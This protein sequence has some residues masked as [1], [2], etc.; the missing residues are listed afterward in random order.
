[1]PTGAPRPAYSQP[2]NRE[3]DP[4]TD[5]TSR[6]R[7]QAFAD[8]YDDTDFIA[9][10]GEH[11]LLHSDLVDALASPAT[12]PDAAR[13]A[14]IR[15]SLDGEPWST[16]AHDL[17]HAYDSATAQREEARDLA[18]ALHSALI[19]VADDWDQINRYDQRL[20]PDYCLP[21]WLT[22]TAGSPD[23]W[24]PDAAPGNNEDGQL[25]APFGEPESTATPNH[26]TEA[27]QG[28]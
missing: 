7:V 22:N 6:A 23:T 9:K 28:V 25:V 21:Y 8:A 24:Q 5:P 16:A 13:I 15:S 18:R 1:M 17:L 12:G 2:T 26:A 27:E 4:M 10:A 3:K 19:E 14:E 11:E 20:D